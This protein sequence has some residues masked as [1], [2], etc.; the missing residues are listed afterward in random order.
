MQ[1]HLHIVCFDVPF[2]ANYGGAIDVFHTIRC[3]H[4]AGFKLILHC[5]EYGS[6]QKT[7]V[8]NQYTEKIYYYPRQTSF[9]K[10]LS[11]LPFNVTSRQNQD[12]KK[13]LLQDNYPILFEVL[14]TCELMADE[15]LK[16][17][18][19]I[20]RHSNI[21]H[22]YF[23]ELAKNERSILKKIYL[24]LEAF[25][26]KRF[27]KVLNH[28]NVILSV[29]EKDLHYFKTHFPSINSCYLPSFHQF[30]KI[31]STLGKGEYILYHGN[32]SVSENYSAALWLIEK[33]FSQ[34]TFPVVIAGLNAPDILITKIKAYPHIS[35]K[36]NLTEAEMQIV[37]QQA[38]IH[39]LYTNQ[40]TGLKLKLLSVLYAGRHVLV[41]KEMLVGTSLINACTIANTAGEYLNQINEL[42]HKSFSNEDIQKRTV[43]LNEMNNDNKTKKFIEILG[44]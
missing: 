18:F 7:D 36:Q 19:K 14:H 22:D 16:E 8:L 34:I 21:E 28:A 12:L 37:I 10:H 25:K 9:S 27:E 5:F 31:T 40:S 20:Y 30:D 35:L 44:L 32:L 24:K 3:L 11:L 4:A 17:R 15:D 42:M 23:N 33:V 13:N 43:L 41:N 6:R 1:N 29:S 39:C 2:P 38:H 26:L